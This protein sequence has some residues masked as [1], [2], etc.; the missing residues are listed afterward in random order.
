MTGA[1]RREWEHQ[2]GVSSV[3][4]CARAEVSELFL[5]GPDYK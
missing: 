2:E 1:I 5:K 3:A 4:G